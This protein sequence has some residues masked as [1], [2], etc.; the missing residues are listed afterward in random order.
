MQPVS[1]PA[2]CNPCPHVQVLKAVALLLISPCC[3]PPQALDDCIEE[4]KDV[5]A[6][7]RRAASLVRHHP[8]GSSSDTGAYRRSSRLGS[9]DVA[10]AVTD[11]A[12]EQDAVLLVTP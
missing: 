10:E 11:S 12:A 6:V 7:Q 9:D 5:P 1:L 3:C 2:L 4:V 8:R